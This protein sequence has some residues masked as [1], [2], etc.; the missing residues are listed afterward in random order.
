MP[1]RETAEARNN[2]SSPQITRFA[3]F[4]RGYALGLSLIVAAL[5]ILGGYSNVL[6]FFAGT[7]ALVT[8]LTSLASYL[9]VGYIFFQRLSLADLYFPVRKIEGIRVSYAEEERR[10]RNFSRVPLLLTIASLLLFGSYIFATSSA[11]KEVAYLDAERPTDK[12]PIA[13]IAPSPRRQ[14]A[15][16]ML[17]EAI[18]F[19]VF[20]P[21]SSSWDIQFP[22]QQAVST[23]LAKTPN[24]EQPLFFVTTP[25]FLL[26]FVFASATFV[27]MGLRDYLQDDQR[28]SD[29]ELLNVA[30]TVK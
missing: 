23:I 26:A 22:N 29:K 10:I 25:L 21:N 15:I 20:H 18:A 14:H 11:V 8:V 6:P 1:E 19:T 30:H 17:D 16:L 5:P 12:T 27:L 9:A 24:V 7:K 3:R 28:I 4:F 2:G 13:E